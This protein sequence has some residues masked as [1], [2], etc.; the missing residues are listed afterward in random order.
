MAI[1]QG[2]WKLAGSTGEQPQ[3]LRPM[4]LADEG[5]LEEQIMQDVSILNRDWLLIGRQVRTGFD[6][7]I[8]LLAIDANGTMIIIELKRDKTPRDVVAQAIDYASW[9]VTLADYQLIEIYQTFAERYQRPHTTLEDAFEAKFGIPLDGVTLN[10]NHQLVVVATQLDA[11]SERI[12]NYLNEYAQLSINAMFFAS[13]ED[14]GN[15]YLSRAWMIDPDEPPQPA[16]HKTRKEP[17]NGEFYASFGD[18]RPWELARHYGFIAGRGAAWYSKTLAMLS[19][20]DRVWVN[21]PK[22]GYVGVGVVIGERCR[23]DQFM[24]QTD[25]G[26]ARLQDITTA[27]DYPHLYRAID[28]DDEEA[29]EYLVP[30]RWIAS[31]PASQ[32]FSEV[33]LFGNQNTVC[34]PTAPKWDHTVAR[35]KQ[36]WKIDESW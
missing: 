3:K 12:I 8:D 16:A 28:A 24:V 19:Q 20:G 22:T 18:N 29:A 25:Q 32:A 14:Q 35:L 34:K 26:S 21:I 17:W 36:A 30:V 11:S 7:L 27:N 13:F 5:Q 33:G 23:A 10:E 4:G 1:E 31:F 6:K 15:R 9:V 2:I